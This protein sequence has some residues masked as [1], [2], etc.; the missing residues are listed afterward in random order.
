[1]AKYEQSS[2][3]PKDENDLLETLEFLTYKRAFAESSFDILTRSDNLPSS[4]QIGALLS[5]VEALTDKKYAS[6]QK[7]T[8]EYVM[9]IEIDE[10]EKHNRILD[11]YENFFT[12]I[13]NCLNYLVLSY[14]DWHSY[15]LPYFLFLYGIGHSRNLSF[16]LKFNRLMQS[17]ITYLKES[18]VEGQDSKLFEVFDS[19]KIGCLAFK[20]LL[21]A[22]N[23]NA[24]TFISLI[25][26][27]RATDGE[28]ELAGYLESLLKLV[29]S[30]NLSKE[31]TNKIFSCM[32]DKDNPELS[33]SIRFGWLLEE[34][35]GNMNQQEYFLFF[36]TIFSFYY[37]V[38]MIYSASL[39][40]EAVLS[41]FYVQH[42][43]IG[44]L[45]LRFLRQLTV[46]L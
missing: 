5:L 43:T 33:P 16:N 12:R 44:N 3:E 29:S 11:E 2:Q 28:K 30:L 45:D 1:M 9:P 15:I 46:G 31:K 19:Y 39:S 10:Q 18:S 6:L 23:M 22:A 40:P 25:K 26:R 4:N 13:L 14:K 36:D 21:A 41:F 38:K 8:K 34:L 35:R 24:N 42:Y 32:I 20:Y 7:Y 17:M 37:I 27:V